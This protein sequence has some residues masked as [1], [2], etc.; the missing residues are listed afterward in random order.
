VD[1]VEHVDA[2]VPTASPWIVAVQS[3]R[4]NVIPMVCLWSG[5]VLLL[6]LYYFIPGGAALFEPLMVWQTKGGCLAAFFNRVVFLA[7]LPGVFLLSV[8]AIRPPR[9]YL[10]IFAYALWG[11]AWGVFDDVFF[12]FLVR[13]FGTGTDIGTLLLKTLVGQLVG[14]ILVGLVPGTLFFRWVAADFSVARV[15]AEWPQHFFRGACVSLLLANWIVWIPVN[16]CTFAFPLPLQIQLVGLAG[17]FWM[18]VGLQTGRR[19]SDC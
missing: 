12:T 4:A 13:C 6:C 15:R 11:G 5:A 8:R 3:V 19:S 9:P 17:C 1:A 7:L 18:L 14:T 2:V 10:T 16:I